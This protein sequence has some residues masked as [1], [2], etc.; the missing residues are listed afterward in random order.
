MTEFALAIFIGVSIGSIV[1]SGFLLFTK[2][3]RPLKD[4]YTEWVPG[5]EIREDFI[6]GHEKDNQYRDSA[7]YEIGRRSDGVLVWR[8]KEG[9]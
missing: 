1:L 9:Y 7:H 5:L 8:R 3:D 6:V 2:Q 4:Q